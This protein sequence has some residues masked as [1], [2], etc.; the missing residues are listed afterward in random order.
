MAVLLS[1]LINNERCA[2]TVRWEVVGCFSGSE[3]LLPE[4]SGRTIY[5]LSLFEE[6]L[7]TSNQK[8]FPVCTSTIKILYRL[9]VARPFLMLKA[10]FLTL[11]LK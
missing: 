8:L 4:E 7:C 3:Q 11:P 1:A 6:I 10:L 5:S 2:E 9:G